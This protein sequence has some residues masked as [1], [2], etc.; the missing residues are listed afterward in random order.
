[1]RMNGHRTK[2]PNI[3][4]FANESQTSQLL[5][6]TVEDLKTLRARNAGPPYQIKLNNV[7][8]L[9]ADLAKYIMQQRGLVLNALEQRP[10]FLE[11]LFAQTEG[12]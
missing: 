4:R 7:Y 9:K 2:A 11:V 5:G 12:G 10:H 3:A 1:M 6:L 8:Y